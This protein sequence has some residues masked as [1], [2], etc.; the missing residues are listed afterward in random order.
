MNSVIKIT[1]LI[2]HLDLSIEPFNNISFWLKQNNNLRKQDQFLSIYLSLPNGDQILYRYKID[3]T[4]Q[5][6]SN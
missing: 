6:I 2:N 3:S 5:F 4:G 1:G